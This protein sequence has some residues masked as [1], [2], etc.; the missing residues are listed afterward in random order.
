MA[1]EHEKSLNIADRVKSDEEMKARTDYVQP[2]RF[3]LPR[4]CP[5]CLLARVKCEC[6]TKCCEQEKS[7]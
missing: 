1:H 6:E 5:H 7:T 4:I 3:G 2:R